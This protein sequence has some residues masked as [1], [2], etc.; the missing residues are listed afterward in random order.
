MVEGK[1]PERRRHVAVAEQDHLFFDVGYRV[2]QF[3]EYES[4]AQFLREARQLAL[5]LRERILQFRQE[6]PSIAAAA[7]FLITRAQRSRNPWHLFHAGVAAGYIGRIGEARACFAKIMENT[8]EYD[9]QKALHAKAHD[10]AE[11][12]NDPLA[13]KTRIE[14]AV[15]N[16]RKLLKLPERPKRPTV[17]S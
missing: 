8:P 4:E 10:L 12:L 1:L 17:I 7:Q 6:F 5:S 3:V 9:W 16:T 11:L 13:F 2:E 15:G 14:E